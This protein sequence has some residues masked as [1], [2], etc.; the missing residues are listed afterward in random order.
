[1]SIEQLKGRLAIELADAQASLD[2]AGASLSYYQNLVNDKTKERDSLQAA[3][4]ALEGR[5]PPPPIIVPSVF[6]QAQS[7]ETQVATSP[8]PHPRDKDWKPG[9]PIPGQV[10]QID[11]E[12]V[13]LEPGM[14][15]VKNSFGEDCIVPEDTPQFV[16]MEEPVAPV[17]PET[18]T[19][20]IAATGTAEEFDDPRNLY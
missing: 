1:M 10:V 11:G 2:A 16:P 17:N 15:V 12:D 8:T 19:G 20:G 18:G 13:I 4:D 14:K 9:K 7:L 6:S 3:L 5:T